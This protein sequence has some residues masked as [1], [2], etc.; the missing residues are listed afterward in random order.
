MSRRGS[1]KELLCKSLPRSYFSPKSY[2]KTINELTHASKWPEALQI[3]QVLRRRRHLHQLDALAFGAELLACSRG[4]RW[5]AALH[6]LEESRIQRIE[7]NAILFSSVLSAFAGARRWQRAVQLLTQAEAGEGRGATNIFSYNA[8]ISATGGLWEKAIAIFQAA[9]VHR[10]F[11]SVV[12]FNA[13]ITSCERAGRWDKALYLLEDAKQSWALKRDIVTFNA[14][15]AACRGG[16]G[17]QHGLSLLQELRSPRVRV[18]KGLPH[19]D[20]V[21]FNAAAAACATSQR[22]AHAL[23][24]VEVMKEDSLRP[25]T[26]TWNTLISTCQQATQW[27]RSLRFYE[28]M[29][30]D[31]VQPDLTTFGAV[32]AATESAMLWELSLKLYFE[33]LGKQNR[34]EPNIAVFNALMASCRGGNRWEIILQ[35]LK[36]ARVSVLVPDMLSFGIAATSL[37]QGGLWVRA[38]NLLSALEEGYEVRPTAL[39]QNT[40][41]SACERGGHRRVLPLLELLPLRLTLGSL[42]TPMQ[43]LSLFEELSAQK[44]CFLVQEVALHGRKIDSSKAATE[45]MER[46]SLLD[47][48]V[49][50]ALGDLQLTFRS[51]PCR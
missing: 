10:H 42:G 18:L 27:S 44:M 5:D 24:L 6:V 3:S 49:R 50:E 21:T 32:L 4:S 43:K 29:Q 37:A 46:P 26:I 13:L 38:V 19:P 41:L 7:L 1:A 15:I 28:K 16:G 36:L 20:V 8:V 12:T 25:T 34:L 23:R 48:T 47:W 17:W 2:T 11:P 40:V 35:M 22:W 51:K 14:A 31:S 33:D 45:V 9:K 30:S 39:L